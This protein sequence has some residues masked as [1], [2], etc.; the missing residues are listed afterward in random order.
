MLTVLEAIQLSTTY[1]EKKGVES[2]RTN[3]ELLLAD[4]L[5]CKRLELYL[6]FD[7]PLKDIELDIYRE[8]IKKRGHRIP[9]QYILGY[10]DFYGYKF[11]VDQNVLIPRPETELLVEKIIEDN[12]AKDKLRILDIGCGSGNIS[13]VIANKIMQSDVIGIDVSAEAIS[14][15]EKNKSAIKENDNITFLQIDILNASV[16]HLGKFD[17]IVSNPPYISL[18]DFIELEPELRDYEP[19][20]SLTDE[21]DGLSFYRKIVSLS[22]QMLNPKGRIYFEVGKDQYKPIS[23]MMLK[24]G[25][26]NMKVIKDYS[27]IERIVYGELQ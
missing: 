17:I 21:L 8:F 7:K 15:A 23:E 27:G 19:R 18:N 16:E 6:S 2:A 10:V 11:C 12:S 24:T 14:N 4:I 13:L 26:S 3:A 5:N 20:I 9:L 1:L 22:K 25:F